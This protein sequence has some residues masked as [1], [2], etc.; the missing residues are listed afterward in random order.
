MKKRYRRNQKL[1]I[2]ADY[3]NT[4]QSYGIVKLIEYLRP[5]ETFTNDNEKDESGELIIYCYERWIVEFISSK[6]YKPG[7][8]KQH[9]IRFNFRDIEPNKNIFTYYP[10]EKHR[11]VPDEDRP[12]DEYQ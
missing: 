9:N 3:H 10:P 5:G 6:Q 8:R 2:Y 1:E 12:F 7:W 4:N 11:P